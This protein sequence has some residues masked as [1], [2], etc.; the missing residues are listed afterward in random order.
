M[1]CILSIE[2][3]TSVC[4]VALHQSGNLLALMELHQENVHSRELMLLVAQIMERSGIS[5]EQLDAVAVSSGP[6]SYTGLRIGVSIAKGLAFAQDIPLIGVDTLKALAKRAQSFVFGDSHIIPMLDA[7]R[8]EVYVTVFDKNLQVVSPLTPK[9]IE[10][11][12]PYMDLLE[13]G[14]VYFVGDGVAKLENLLNHPNAMLLKLL[15]SAETVGFLAY[16]KFKEGVFEDLA[17]FEPNYLKDFRVIS[18]KK[19]LLLS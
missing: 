10:N 11:E 18:A 2:S 6:G 5:V 17:Y 13:K 12:N 9:V 3:T 15:P 8:M 16:D 1:S 4:S 19:N 7:R 14:P